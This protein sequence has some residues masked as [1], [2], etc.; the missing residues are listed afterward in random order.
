MLL[1]ILDAVGKATQR[2]EPTRP[3][4]EA[5]AIRYAAI[6]ERLISPEGA[7]PAIGCS[8]AYR[9]GT[10]HHLAEISLRHQLPEGSTV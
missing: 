5:R 1:N 9:Y 7:Y 2:W 6:Q 4:I 10:F 3:V 8:L